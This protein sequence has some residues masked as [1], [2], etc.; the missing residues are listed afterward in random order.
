MLRLCSDPVERLSYTVTLCPLTASKSVVWEPMKPAPPVIN[1]LMRVVPFLTE[2]S[3]NDDQGRSVLSR[4]D[5]GGGKCLYDRPMVF[6]VRGCMR[7][8]MGRGRAS[9]CPSGYAL[10]TGSPPFRFR[11]RQ[12]PRSL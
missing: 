10:G 9:R 2:L 12:W 7:L 4:P 11:T 6:P 1:I 8:C 3:L 5:P